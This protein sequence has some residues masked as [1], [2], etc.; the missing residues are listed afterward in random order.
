MPLD[1]TTIDLP[2][3]AGQDGQTSKTALPPGRPIS[4]KNAAFR[5]AGG[6]EKRRGF[7]T[8]L[9]T[10]SLPGSYVR[11]G[12]F[13]TRGVGRYDDGT[14]TLAEYSPT[15][16]KWVP[17][18]VA[19]TLRMTGRVAKSS[20]SDIQA[21]DSYSSG[22]YTILAW[23]D[24]TGIN[25]EITDDATGAVVASGTNVTGNGGS[26]H[27][28]CIGTTL[29][30]LTYFFIFDNSN[31]LWS[32]FTNLS[33]SWVSS[34]GGILWGT[35]GARRT[36]AYTD[37]TYLYIFG[38][39]GPSNLVRDRGKFD[40]SMATQWVVNEVVAGIDSTNAIAVCASYA[41]NFL[42]TARVQSSALL[43][44]CYSALD[45]S[46]IRSASIA[47]AVPS[48]MS[49]ARVDD[50]T[51]ILVYDDM[52]SA[53][54]GGAKV[55]QVEVGFGVSSL[56]TPTVLFR[57]AS[58]ASDVFQ[59]VGV[60]DTS[61]MYFAITYYSEVSA[62]LSPALVAAA[63][64]AGTRSVATTLNSG[65]F[66]VTMDG[67]YCGRAF[68]GSALTQP[69]C[70]STSKGTAGLT[71]TARVLSL[72]ETATIQSALSLGGVGLLRFDLSSEPFR[73]VTA[74]RDMLIPGSRPQMYDGSSVTELGFPI[75]PEFV[76]TY[77]S[78]AGGSWTNILSFS[79]GTPYSVGDLVPAGTLAPGCVLVCV[80]AGQTAGVAPSL[81]G[82]LIVD[83][84]V[85]WQKIAADAPTVFQANGSAYAVAA[86]VLPT[87]PNGF[88]YAVQTL[89]AGSN[90]I[91][92]AE[93][94]WPTTI[95]ATVIQTTTDSHNMT[96]VCLAAWDLM[97]AKEQYVFASCYSWVDDQGQ[98]QRSALSPTTAVTLPTP[99]GNGIARNALVVVGTCRLTTKTGVRIE[100]YSTSGNGVV[101]QQVGT[102]A[103]N[104]AVDAV[105]W[106]DII[107][108][109]T[110]ALGQVCAQGPLGAGQLAPK[111]PPPC[112]HMATYG[113][114][115][116]CNDVENPYSLC[117]SM[118]TVDGYAV[119]WADELRVPLNGARGEYVAGCAMDG[120]F[121]IFQERAISMIAGD[122]VDNTGGGVPFGQPVEIAS[123]VGC[124]TADSVILTP[125]G[126]VFQ[127]DQGIYLLDRNRTVQF[128]GEPVLGQ[129][130]PIQS[131]C[132]DPATHQVVF[133][134]S[135]TK[136][137]VWD[138][139]RNSWGQWLLN[140]DLPT[141]VAVFDGSLTISTDGG[142]VMPQS[143][144]VYVDRGGSYGMAIEIAPVKIAGVQGYG[145]VKRA[146][147]H[148]SFSGSSPAFQVAVKNDYSDSAAY[149]LNPV[150][151]TAALPIVQVLFR[152]RKVTAVGLV[153]TESTPGGYVVLDGVQFEVGVK[154]GLA[155]IPVGNRSG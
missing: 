43:V 74:F 24:G 1:W 41:G 5:K 136:L 29:F 86:T 154:P 87:T 124:A 104:P 105:A 128:I 50:G 56:G 141:F 45:G 18:G 23:Y 55:M 78:A 94:T 60:F 9:G 57:S 102:I 142:T 132:I 84:T 108:D 21:C 130:G 139:L 7:P 25:V 137:W 30:G 107:P 114:R 69:N 61:A 67:Q 76:R 79:R 8:T 59:D 16:D 148:F 91:P 80:V 35:G 10:N 144:D 134:D 28:Q 65:V 123:H 116:M 40:F 120:T 22:G 98:L 150:T 70:A 44:E 15:E 135:N 110:Q 122:G 37:G 33:G 125:A 96:F 3:G 89:N 53:W 68:R 153:I 83:G 77:T 75:Y 151:P 119:A 92:T 133:T 73:P 52:T 20:S 111:P 147:L 72:A 149:T 14:G 49:F 88:I 138:W 2:L 81:S 63:Q 85:T 143:S 42:Y 17:R 51:A 115:A 152:T 71:I 32:R 101:L 109:T 100:I 129:V 103:N 38:V 113:Q 48:H 146:N 121:Y 145:R 4:L 112:T 19:R 11:L 27:V 46:F 6:W 127:S 131:A 13:G 95:G 66:L 64:A 93:P 26:A 62:G 34:S 99:T 47:G 58:L 140:G 117:P 90:G 82:T 12:S 155:R 31:S 97:T 126:I 118:L 39:G 106:A 54:A 36:R